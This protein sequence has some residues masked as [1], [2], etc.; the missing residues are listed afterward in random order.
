MTGMETPYTCVTIPVGVLFLRKNQS[1][2]WNTSKF[3]FMKLS[4]KPVPH[5]R[6]DTFLFLGRTRPGS[7]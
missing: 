6:N 3:F 1:Y 5:T 4:K 7:L 2:P